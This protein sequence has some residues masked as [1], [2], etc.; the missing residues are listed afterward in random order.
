MIWSVAL[1]SSCPSGGAALGR[2]G[3][4]VASERLGA[5]MRHAR[6][7]VPVLGRL[8]SGEKVDLG[9]LGLVILDVGPGSFTGVRVGVAVAK[10]IYLATRC[11]VVG[12]LATDAVTAGVGER[13]PEVCVVIDAT[14]GE[15]YA[16]RYRPSDQPADPARGRF[17]GS[18][19]TWERVFG[20]T[21]IR[22]ADLL[23]ALGPGCYVTGGGLS[24]HGDVFR[25]GALVLASEPGWFPAVEWVHA[26][27]WERYGKGLADDPYALEP[28]YL[29]LPAAEER[30]RERG[31]R[32]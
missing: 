14:R 26:L 12:V 23:P 24:R 22:P 7:M 28:M 1:E 6:D 27:G 10:A 8:A 5:G 15:L 21:I 30:W 20:P 29:R 16:A 13:H 17:S 18:A 2:D 11:Q 32:A 4:V 19:G 25:G 9:Q 31:G 3:E